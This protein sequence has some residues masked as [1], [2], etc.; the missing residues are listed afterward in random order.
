MQTGTRQQSGKLISSLPGPGNTPLV[1]LLVL[2]VQWLHTLGLLEFGQLGRVGELEE[3]RGILNQ[4]LRIDSGDLPEV[5]LGS[6][7][8]L[9]EHNPLRLPVKEG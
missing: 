2:V 6:L 7:Y 8:H 3:G 9:V 1:G 5:L 4:P